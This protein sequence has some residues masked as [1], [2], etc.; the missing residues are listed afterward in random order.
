MEL[1]PWMSVTKAAIVGTGVTD[2]QG[3]VF[4][5]FGFCSTLFLF[6][7]DNYFT[8]CLFLIQFDNINMIVS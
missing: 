7:L 6:N 2:K 8:Y 1:A 4:I 5:L 3:L